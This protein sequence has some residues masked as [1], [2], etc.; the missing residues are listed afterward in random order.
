MN[1]LDK[2]KRL[3]KA[4]KKGITPE[5]QRVFDLDLEEED[6]DDEEDSPRLKPR[7]FDIS[8]SII[9]ARILRCCSSFFGT[10]IVT[11]AG[12]GCSTTF[13]IFSSFLIFFLVLTGSE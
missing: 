8:A 11:G 4:F 12:G 13:S 3:V 10:G 6:D 1:N 9:R 7:G 5:G 2:K